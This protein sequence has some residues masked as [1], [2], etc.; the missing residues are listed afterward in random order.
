MAPKMSVRS[1]QQKK[2]S[3]KGPQ[4]RRPSA[5]S[6]VLQLAQ[7]IADPCTGPLVQPQYGASDGGY[8][9]KFS[10][11]ESLN[12][13][14]GSTAGY[15][16]WFPDYEGRF[17]G[18]DGT[19]NGSLFMF[20]GNGGTSAPVNTTAAPLGT[21]LTADAINGTFISDPARS[22]VNSDTVQDSRTAAACMKFLYTG[23]N[24]ALAGRIGYLDAVP[25]EALLTGSAG[26]TPPSV[27]D[28][29]RYSNTSMRTPLDTVEQK[30]RPG[31]GSDVYRTAERWE[32]HCLNQGTVGSGVTTVGTGT[33]SGVT[34]G[35]G[36]VWDGVYDGSSITF[37]L[38]KAI[39]WRPELS[40]GLVSVKQ[41]VAPQGGNLVSK[42]LAYLDGKHPGWERKAFSAAKSL[43]GTVASAAFSGP[44]NKILRGAA[45][46]LLT[47]I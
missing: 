38:L 23:R 45:P 9:A 19:S 25:R 46:L 27:D 12:I 2:Q 28:M 3:R 41:T 34:T 29:F 7:M 4:R 40:S 15:C 18:T 44:E 33:P 8:L 21:G 36:F 42:S 30:F 39:E 26:G 22:F 35:I 16:I 11:Y 14:T 13:T 10:H 5:P 37:D 6:N 24:D 31:E 20:A 32:D 1:K 43:M 47:M 17:A